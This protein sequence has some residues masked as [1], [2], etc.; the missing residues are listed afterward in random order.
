MTI[1]R[2]HLLGSLAAATVCTPVVSPAYAADAA[3]PARASPNSQSSEGWFLARECRQ[4]SAD[5]AV[6]F[7]ERQFG[8][9]PYTRHLP[10]EFVRGAIW[11]DVF[12]KPDCQT[13]EAI[14]RSFQEY[15]FDWAEKPRR[16]AA[17]SN[18][19]D[20]LAS[21]LRSLIAEDSLTSAP[22]TAFLSLDSFGPLQEPSWANV[23][24]A[25]R[26]CYDHVIGHFHLPQRGLR[27]WRN[28]LTAHFEEGHFQEHFV[29][30]AAQCD[31]VIL[32]SAALCESDVRACPRASIEELAA[33]L[34]RDLGCALLTPNVLERIVSA[35]EQGAA[36]KP[37]LFALASLHLW[38]PEDYDLDFPR[39]FNRQGALVRGSFG[40]GIGERPLLVATAAEDVSRSG[41]AVRLL[42]NESFF[43]TD[44]PACEVEKSNHS[45]F[46]YLRMITLWPFQLDAT[47]PSA[48]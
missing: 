5:N 37:R 38:T 47:T 24:P 23:L 30:A 21:A 42:T 29:N 8:D 12:G 4:Q 33:E 10:A 43:T 36:R 13:P 31:A 11:Y 9:V 44:I 2:R 7:W 26:S 15:R 28:L 25:F 35:G 45:I 18:G 6:D 1:D 27:Q 16:F 3:A 20:T 48:A 46:N 34:V 32:T 14:D 41:A 19:G 22:R 17:C 39:M 40:D